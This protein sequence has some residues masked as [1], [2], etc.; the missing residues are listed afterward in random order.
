MSKTLAT[1][2][3]PDAETVAAV[4]AVAAQTA[5]QTA[6]P[7]SSAPA[8]ILSPQIAESEGG[9]ENT[10]SSAP[11]FSPY[12]GDL[13]STFAQDAPHTSLPDIAMLQASKPA[14]SPPLDPA[15]YANAGVDE[16]GEEMIYFPVAD[17]EK[18]TYVL[19]KV[20]LSIVASQ[21]KERSWEGVGASGLSTAMYD[22]NFSYFWAHKDSDHPATVDARRKSY[23]PVRESPTGRMRS[24]SLQTA[25]GGICPS[26]RLATFG[27]WPVPALLR[28][29]ARRT[30]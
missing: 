20:P 17:T 6:V 7:A 26:L 18:D 30:G 11:P 15:P 25:A 23:L 27:L 8:S 1:R 29:C 12:Q 14:P 24:S 5:P 22:Q 2:G 10:S 4:A 19:K 21:M 9:D 16:D 13:M 28:R 3:L